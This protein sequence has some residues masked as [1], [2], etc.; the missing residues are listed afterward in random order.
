MIVIAHRLS[1]IR[2]VDTI[3]L[4]EKGEILISGDFETM[5]ENSERFK[6]MVDLQGL[7]KVS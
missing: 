5:I 4:L 3:Y 1:T 6:R 2:N 7:S